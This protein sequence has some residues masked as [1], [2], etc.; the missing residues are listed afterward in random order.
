V[1]DELLRLV[2]DAGSLQSRL[3]LVLG[4]DDHQRR[5]LLARAAVHLGAQVLPLGVD[6]ARRMAAVPR[7]QRPLQAA[8]L[9]RDAVDAGFA[10]SA[11]AIL[12]RTE[13]LFDRSLQ[14]DALNALKR[15]AHSRT[16]VASWPGELRDRRLT[17]APANHPEHC[18]HPVAGFL[19]Y[20]LS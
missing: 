2:T 7:K 15:L 1:L 17:Y 16:V 11:A 3:V 19:D 5:D 13:V 14:L 20:Q 4:G 6:Y 9:L 18:D 8:S 10:P 12:D